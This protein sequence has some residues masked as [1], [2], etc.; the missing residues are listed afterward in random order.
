MRTNEPL[1]Y[2]RRIGPLLALDAFGEPVLGED[3]AG[4]GELEIAADGAE[5]GAGAGTVGEIGKGY[6]YYGATFAEAG[7]TRWLAAK[8]SGPCEEFT[9]REDVEAAP[10]G[11]AIGEP[12]ATKRRIGPLLA[13]DEDGNELDAAAL[14]TVTVEVTING[15]ALAPAAGSLTMLDDGYPYYVADLSELTERGWIAVLISGTC[16]DFMMR[17]D[18]VGAAALP[19]ALVKHDD[20]PAAFRVAGDLALT[21]SNATGNADLS[22]VDFDLA[23]DQGLVTAMELSLFTDRRAEPD[24][25]PPSGDPRDRRG[26]WA[27][28]FAE[29]E[30]DKFGSR[31]WLLDRSKNTNET[32]LR[33]EEYVREAWAWMLEDRVVESVDVEIETT[34]RAL[35]IAGAV[36]RPGRDPVS[37]RFAHT[38]D[39]LQET[40]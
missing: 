27:D 2:A 9:F 7:A 34:D 13:V 26:W 1:A 31:L 18:V 8:I 33:A 14:A 24:D 35:L 11:I 4:A 21:W 29:V 32:K 16:E 5:F 19:T 12:D 23:T 10:S 30:G 15:S 25:K 28:E 20:T 38:W 36:H 40:A 3:F 39:H 37:F 22:T 6:Y 17:E